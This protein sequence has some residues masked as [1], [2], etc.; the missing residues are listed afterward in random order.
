MQQITGTY[1]DQVL[2]PEPYIINFS[3]KAAYKRKAL[4]TATHYRIYSVK[5][6][7][8]KLCF[9]R[10]GTLLGDGGGTSYIY[11]SITRAYQDLNELIK[12]GLDVKALP[13]NIAHE[14]I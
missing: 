10:N 12:F 2:K 6:H 3:L 7:E 4:A 11:N 9:Y 14:T 8:V 5:E 13:G 1:F